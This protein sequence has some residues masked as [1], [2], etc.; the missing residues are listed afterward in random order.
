MNFKTVEVTKGSF[1]SS[2]ISPFHSTVILENN[3]G[4]KLLINTVS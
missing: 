1:I 2:I 3:F 4:K